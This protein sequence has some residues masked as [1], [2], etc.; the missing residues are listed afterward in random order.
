MNPKACG[1]DSQQRDTGLLT[2]LT[3]TEADGA[4]LVAER[5]SIESA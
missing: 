2:E 3:A 1:E 4:S 5:V